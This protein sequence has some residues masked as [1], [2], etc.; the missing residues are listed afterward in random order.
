MSDGDELA[1]LRPRVSE[2]EHALAWERRHHQLAVD[3]LAAA[4]AT[5]TDITAEIRA[6]RADRAPAVHREDEFTPTDIGPK[7]DREQRHA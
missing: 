3:R 7:T 4:D 2:L 1:A 5:I 6:L